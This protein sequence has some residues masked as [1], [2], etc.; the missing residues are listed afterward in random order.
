MP[1][2][3]FPVMPDRTLT[4]MPD[5]I[6]H[7]DP[8]RQVKH[9]QARIYGRWPFGRFTGPQAP[10]SRHCRPDRQSPVHFNLNCRSS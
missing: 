7:L 6:G 9:P 2:R 5:L 1:D 10:A 3:P 8:L 4:V